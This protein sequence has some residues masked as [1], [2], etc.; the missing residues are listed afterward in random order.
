MIGHWNGLDVSGFKCKS[1]HGD[2]WPTWKIF[3][4]WK[5]D[6]G[7]CPSAVTG[8]WIFFVLH[9]SGRTILQIPVQGWQIKQVSSVTASVFFKRP[10]RH[11][12][13]LCY[14]F[15]WLWKKKNTWTPAIN[16][17]GTFL[18]CWRP[19]LLNVVF[20]WFVWLRKHIEHP[21][22]CKKKS[23]FWGTAFL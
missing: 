11:I 18:T 21:C 14:L 10:L 15:V 6:E 23:S 3:K 9:A 1:L 12:Y 7:L 13:F 2:S 16:F 8:N 5:N 19:S 4:K 22:S 20:N 17:V